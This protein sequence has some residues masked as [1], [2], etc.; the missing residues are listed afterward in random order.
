MGQVIDFQE[1]KEQ[2]ESLS[3]LEE[4]EAYLA[5]LKARFEQ[6]KNDG[7]PSQARYDNPIMKELQLVERKG[8]VVNMGAYIQGIIN[9]MEDVIESLKNEKKNAAP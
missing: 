6:W 2:K 4:K 9:D 8:T 7:Y 5:D 3:L 1:F